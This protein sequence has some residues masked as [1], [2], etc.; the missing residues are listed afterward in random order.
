MGHRKGLSF[1]HLKRSRVVAAEVARLSS[2]WVWV[3][4][5]LR[6]R[7]EEAV[8]HQK[9]KQQTPATAIGIADRAWD[10][11]D[12]LSSPVWVLGMRNHAT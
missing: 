9:F 12:V 2:N 4:S 8:G 6:V 7:V 3:H 1:A 11:L 10:W 5:S